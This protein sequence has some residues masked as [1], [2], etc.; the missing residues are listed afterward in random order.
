MQPNGCRYG[1][2]KKTNKATGGC[3]IYRTVFKQSRK[4]VLYAK[5]LISSNIVLILRNNQLMQIISIC[6]IV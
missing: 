1:N 3:E 2:T 4:E 6:D 5:Y